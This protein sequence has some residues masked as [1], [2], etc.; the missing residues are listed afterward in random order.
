M[1]E[2]FS[3]ICEIFWCGEQSFINEPGLD[4]RMARN[5]SGF[6]LP[7]MLTLK[8]NIVNELTDAL[9]LK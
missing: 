5:V 8:L 4:K 2:G 6:T 9:S 1:I 3:S 7:K